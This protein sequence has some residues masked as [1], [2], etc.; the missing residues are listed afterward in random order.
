MK[1]T[2]NLLL[3]FLLL[4]NLPALVAVADDDGGG[5]RSK[6]YGTI[7]RLPAGIFGE[8]VIDGHRV[9]VHRETAFE[10]K[11]GPLAVGA[12]VEVKG[13]NNG[14]EFHASEIE[15]K[16]SAHEGGKLQKHRASFRGEFHGR[17]AVLPPTGLGIW[18]IGQREILVDARTR[19]DERRSP[20]GP[21]TRVKV[22]GSFRDH[23]FHAYQIE[24]VTD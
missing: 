17:V 7:E 14:R 8:W 21:G 5:Y 4:A 24:V 23:R 22:K 13:R 12:Y 11:Y 19:L 10:E 2:R 16:R 15:V 20:I 1:T 6:L 9:Q 18:T 3:L